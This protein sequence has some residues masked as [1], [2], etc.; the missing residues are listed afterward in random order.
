MNEFILKNFQVSK[1]KLC[2]MMKLTLIK[3]KSSRFD[4]LPQW[5]LQSFIYQ[6]IYLFAGNLCFKKCAFFD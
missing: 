2:F 1:E 3:E 4:I 5:P 6:A